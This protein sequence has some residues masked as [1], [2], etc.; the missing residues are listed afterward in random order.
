[1]RSGFPF[2]R[3]PSPPRRHRPPSWS[4]NRTW[5]SEPSPRHH[6]EVDSVWLLV[7]TAAALSLVNLTLLALAAAGLVRLLVPRVRPAVTRSPFWG[8]VMVCGAALLAL[9]TTSLVQIALWATA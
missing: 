3:W 1:M 7:L 5:S 6:R 2:P 4:A 8:S 9:M